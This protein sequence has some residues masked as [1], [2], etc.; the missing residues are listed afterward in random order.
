LSFAAMPLAEA[1]RDR[2]RGISPATFATCLFK[3]G[4]ATG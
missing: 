3:P 2:L 4:C 1:R